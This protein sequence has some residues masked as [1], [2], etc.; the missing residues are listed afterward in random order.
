MDIYVLD[1]SFEIVGI[2][3]KYTSVIWTTR[4]FTYGDFELYMGASEG[5]LSLLQ[6][7]NYLVRQQDMSGGE[8]RNVMII[9]NREITTDVEDG[10]NLIVTGRCLKSI[11]NRRIIINQTILNGT[12]ESCI[13]RLITENIISPTDTARQINNF[14]LGPDT[15]SSSETMKQQITGKNLGEIVSEICA[16]FGIGY[17]V[18]ISNGKF[19]FYLYE[20]TDRTTAQSTNPKV[21]FSSEYDNLISSDYKQS[22]NNFANAVTVAGEG[23]GV[24]RKKVTVGTVSGLDRFEIWVDARNTSSNGGEISETDYLAQLTQEGNE[25]LIEHGVTTS[26]EGQVENTDNCTIGTNYFLGDLVQVENYY[27]ISA[28]TRI[29][30]VIYSEDVNGV[31]VIPTFSEMEV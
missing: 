21:I 16:A 7:G 8:Y 2:I 18:Y 26:F 25:A 15:L 28:A 17:D 22:Y 4:Y 1:T 24:D 11:L 31:D 5:V 14:I 19:V 29:I 23:E 6:K 12:V 9:L 27:G 30:E 10:D 3:D 20:G 13:Q